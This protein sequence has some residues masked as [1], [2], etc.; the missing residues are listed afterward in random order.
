MPIEDK[1]AAA[2]KVDEVLKMLLARGGFRLKYR[3]T[4]APASRS[5]DWEQP[6]IVVDLL[7][8]DSALLLERGGDL[9]RSFEHIAHRALRLD[10]EDHDKVSFDCMNQ[11]AIRLRELKVTAEVAAGQVRKTGVPFE[12]APM[13]ARERRM[14]HLAFQ[15]TADLRTESRGEAGR[16][17]VVVYP[18]NAAPPK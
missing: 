13:S 2:R 17:C 18:Q 15:D 8:P 9:L 1:V 7:G 3:I 4:V 12:F 16:R 11:K 14:I 6:D 10:S 5:T